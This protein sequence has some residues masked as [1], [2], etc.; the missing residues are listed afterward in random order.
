MRIFLEEIARMTMLHSIVKEK[1]TLFLFKSYFYIKP[2]LD[3]NLTKNKTALFRPLIFI[4][5][6]S[7]T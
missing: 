5:I 7:I 1:H 2:T 6:E 4:C 3:T